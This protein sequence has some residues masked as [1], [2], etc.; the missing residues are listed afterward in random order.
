MKCLTLEQRKE[1]EESV[2]RMQEIDEIGDGERE[3]EREKCDMQS[4]KY[5]K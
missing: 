4:E 2:Q 1:N 3:S 5:L